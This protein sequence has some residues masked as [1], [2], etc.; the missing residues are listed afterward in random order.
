MVGGGG[1]GGGGGGVALAPQKICFGVSK[2]LTHLVTPMSWCLPPNFLLTSGVPPQF[3]MS[4]DATGCIELFVP[5]MNKYFNLKRTTP[6]FLPNS[7][8]PTATPHYITL[9]NVDKI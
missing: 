3:E 1:G 7:H 9:N 8:T 2:I 4:S 6:S 5:K